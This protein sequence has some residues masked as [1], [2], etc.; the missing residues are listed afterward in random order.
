MSEEKSKI[1]QL[2]SFEV[3]YIS[4]PLQAKFL[5]QNM[6][7]NGLTKI[8]YPLGEISEEDFMEDILS[9]AVHCFQ[10]EINGVPVA[11]AWLE[12]PEHNLF[13]AH[14]GVFRNIGFKK[15]QKKDLL[16]L[17]GIKIFD[18]FP[19]IEGL[20]GI[21][22][23]KCLKAIN[24]WKDV[25]WFEQIGSFP[26]GFEAYGEKCGANIYLLE[27]ESFYGRK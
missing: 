23:T 19:K 24:F 1:S 13:R 9:N 7:K 17:F 14:T 8:M 25:P 22:P 2:S 15:D 4:R 12:P 6:K 21:I 5:Y 11:F 20:W 16:K 3:V 26:C 27:K 10:A 18:M